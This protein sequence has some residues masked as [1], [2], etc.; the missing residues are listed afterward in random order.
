MNTAKGSWKQALENRQQAY[1]KAY[2][3]VTNPEGYMGVVGG[4]KVY[5]PENFF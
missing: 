1:T 5:S 2:D 4:H 3:P